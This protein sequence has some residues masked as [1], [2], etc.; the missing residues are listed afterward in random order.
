MHAIITDQ[1]SRNQE[2]LAKLCN[3]VAVKELRLFG[4]A[5]TDQF[6]AATSDLDFIAEFHHP[7]EQ[8]IADRYMQLAEGL[9]SLFD[10]PV[11]LI[12]RQSLRN[13]IF[14][15]IVDETSVPVYAG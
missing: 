12:T 15:R 1:I 6:N 9:Q 3:G 13:P 10:R 8:G 14:Q 11:D 5:T 7:D 2:E 4:S